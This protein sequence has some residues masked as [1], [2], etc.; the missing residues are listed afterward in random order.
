MATSS[1]VIPD[2][3]QAQLTSLQSA[4]QSALNNWQSQTNNLAIAK[5]NAQR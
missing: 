4:Y 5:A 3:M 1:V 2:S